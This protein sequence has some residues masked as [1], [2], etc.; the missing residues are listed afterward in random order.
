MTSF[1]C[2]CPDQIADRQFTVSTWRFTDRR[3]D[4]ASDEP[5][6]HSS[7]QENLNDP[8]RSAPALLLSTLYVFS[9]VLNL[10]HATS[11]K[12]MYI[13]RLVQLDLNVWKHRAG[14]YLGAP[15]AIEV[16]CK[17]TPHF[18]DST[19]TTTGYLCWSIREIQPNYKLTRSRHWIYYRIF[20][21]YS[22]DKKRKS[23]FVKLNTKQF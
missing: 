8:L 16:G 5:W 23:L 12:L 11:S 17:C 18:S 15:R 20:I 4:G 14:F 22:Y 2:H 13:A 1:V 9:Y 7:F 10:A 6:L 3:A 19:Y 21:L